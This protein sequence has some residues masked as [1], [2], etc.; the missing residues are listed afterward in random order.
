MYF[1][2]TETCGFHGP[3][4]LIQYADG[5]DGEIIRHN[6]WK[7]TIMDT[8]VLIETIAKEGIVGFNLTFDWFHLCQT[9]TTLALLGEK[10]GFDELPEDHINQYALLE[11]QA[12]DGMCVKP[13]TALDLMLHARKGPYQST[14]DRK[15]IKIKKVPRVLAERLAQ[16]LSARVKLNDIYFAR[17]ADKKKRWQ[18]S[19]I[20]GDPDFVNVELRFKPS[21]ALKALVI[22]AGLVKETITFGDVNVPKKYR[23]YELG[24]APFALAV[25]SPEQDWWGRAKKN[26]KMVDVRAWPAVIKR[27]I[28]HWAYDPKAIVYSIDDVKYLQLLYNHFNRPEAGDN[29]STLACMVGAVR[30]KGF[31]VNLDKIKE[32]REAALRKSKL[33]PKYSKHVYKYVSELMSPTEVTANLTREGQASTKKVLLETIVK[34]LKVD[35]P[36]CGG[37]GDPTCKTCKGDGGVPHPAAERAQLCLDARKSTTDMALFDKLLI[38]GRLHVSLKVIGSLSS[39]MSGTDG[40]NAMGI[41]HQKTVRSAFDLAFPPMELC[42]GDFSAFEVSIADACY[43]DDELRRQLLTCYVCK[44][45]RTIEQYEELYC[46]NCGVAVDKCGNCGKG[47]IVHQPGSN[48]APTCNCRDPKPKGEP[49]NSLRKIHGLFG[50]ELAPGSSYDDILATK[51]K[52]PD[53]YD[54]GK[55][56]IFSQFYGGNFQTLVNRIGISEEVAKNAEAGFATRYTGVGRAKQDNYDKFCSMRQ[57]GGI[58]K[59]VIWNDPADYAESLTGF[60]RYFTLE[61][62]ICRILFDLAND[63]PEEW[64]KLKLKVV[65]R[66]RVQTAGGAL[67]SAIFACSFAIQSL[68]MRAAMN[69][70]IQSTGATITKELQCKMWEIQPAGVHPWQLTPFNIHDEIMCPALPVHKPRLKQIVQDFVKSKKPLIPLIKMDFSTSMQTWADK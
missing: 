7:E 51:G 2:D 67:R 19:E 39:R 26:G 12:R 60:R 23:P 54:Q 5:P 59:E 3:T 49:E 15:N 16:E 29:D 33:A 31:K 34:E 1:V 37:E 17:G 18:I 43:D 41:Q 70:R 6:V 65:R 61:N 8:M 10:V 38:A 11:P 52:D 14:M 42:G 56:G 48:I 20:K 25:S 66:D 28:S 64:T 53:L 30:W 44:Q 22:D 50:Q 9:Y 40:L 32:L 13:T 35:C 55:R 58:G 27:H 4:V 21:S 57:P 47:C 36:A 69:H 45:P 46:P 24:W 63:P 62:E 68:N